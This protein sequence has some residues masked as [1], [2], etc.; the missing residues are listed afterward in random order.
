MA[1]QSLMRSFFSFF[2]IILF[3]GLLS[4]FSVAG[5][6][7]SSHS[8]LPQGFVYLHAIDP[9]IDQK[10]TFA[11]T[12][13]CVGKKLDGYQGHQA[14]CTLAAAKALKKAQK[15]LQ[16]KYPHYSLRVLDAYRPVRAVKHLKRWATDLH[17]TKTKSQCYPHLNKKELA[18]HYVASNQ[19]SHSRGSAVDIVIIN[20]KTGQPLDYGPEFFGKYSHID[21][22]GLRPNQKK[23]RYLLRKLMVKHNFKPYDAEFWHYTLNNEPFPKTYFDFVIKNEK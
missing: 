23:N 20:T 4:V 14:I 15:D 10:L 21:Y 12:H 17:D 11:T 22:K 18:G 7:K 1:E 2:L 19:S 9:S 3:L 6:K 13:N 16:K 5:H 8:H